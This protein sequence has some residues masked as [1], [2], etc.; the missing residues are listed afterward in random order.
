MTDITENTPPTTR[1]VN[2]RQ[3]IKAGAW[4]APVLVLA[5]AAPHA[6][7]A[8]GGSGVTLGAATLARNGGQGSSRNLLVTFSVSNTPGQNALV[9]VA[10]TIQR[11]VNGTW[12]NLAWSTGPTITPT[13]SG[14]TVPANGSTAFAVSGSIGGGIVGPFR[15]NVSVTVT[16]PYSATLPT[17]SNQL[18]IA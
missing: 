4:A 6:A 2:R 9:N 10:V 15:A 1:G 14:A 16:S 3:L 13:A 17:V 11:L 5:T 8:T 12:T 7:A 18:I